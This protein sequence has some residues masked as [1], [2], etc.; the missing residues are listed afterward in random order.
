VKIEDRRLEQVQI[1]HASFD[2]CPPGDCVVW[3]YGATKRNFRDRTLPLAVVWFRRLHQDGSLGNSFSLSMGITDLALLQLGTIWNNGV[4]R[5]QIVLEE[6]EV[7]VNCSP[8]GWRFESQARFSRHAPAGLIPVSA[9]PLHHG[10]RDRSEVLVFNLSERGELLV[11]SMEFFSRC[12]GRD[13][14]VNRVLSTYGWEEAEQRLHLP[15]VEP[16]PPDSWGVCL[17]AN[18]Y[19]YDA[20]F[21]AH[22]K[23]EDQARN[24]A[25]S[26]Y[27]RLNIQFD[28][29]DGL[30]FLKAEPWFSGP[31]K[32][33]VQGIPLDG[34]RFLALRIVGGS[35]PKGPCIWSF[36]EGEG[37][38]GEGSEEDG[39]GGWAG[40][41]GKRAG[42][43]PSM[44]TLTANHTPGHDGDSVE[45]TNP[46]FRI[47]GARRAVVAQKRAR[48][49]TRRRPPMAGEP[50]E[51]YSTGERQGAGGATGVAI[52]R[53][54]TELESQ[55]AA[56]DVWESLLYLHEKWPELIEQVGW[57][58][59]EAGEINLEDKE[60]CMVA[61]TPFSNEQQVGLSKTAR[62]WVY[63]DRAQARVRGV[64]I[65]FVKT[66]SRSA[67]LFEIERRSFQ[68][69]VDDGSTSEK[70]EAFCGLVVSPTDDAVA[71]EWIPR[72]LEG[73]R[74]E[75]GVMARVTRYCSDHLVDYYRRSSSR[76]DEI[77]GHSTVVAALGKAGIG[78][79]HP[80]K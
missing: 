56:R 46:V 22:V 13:A 21:I 29:P 15:L 20:V 45:V 60:P 36:R 12:Y 74:N 73:I 54:E 52:I 33:L 1:R 6:R 19:N 79:P 25:K 76:G 66:A 80:K 75:Q 78:L 24:A 72:V 37:G 40:G 70:E 38:D 49:R 18:V 34:S 61:L 68:H 28:S 62:N 16:I 4:C 14:E 44:V 8:E 48:T 77:A 11:P 69:T 23:Y 32:L 63:A 3:W 7:S 57:Y 51:R 26:I 42:G 10:L 55:G 17:P 39:L 65:A 5:S 67:F 2:P 31:A 64:L 53:T 58:S 35:E 30:A 9:F 43:V 59:P 47:V 50:S 41:R 71:S 27:S